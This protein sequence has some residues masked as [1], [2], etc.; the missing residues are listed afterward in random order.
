M[1]KSISLLAAAATVLSCIR[2]APTNMSYNKRSPF[3]KRGGSYQCSS[4]DNPSLMLTHFAAVFFGDFDTDGGQD[5]LGPLAVQ[6]DFKASGYYVNANGDADCSDPNDISEYALVVGT[7]VHANQVRV[8][9]A[10]DVPAETQGLQETQSSCAIKTN[11]SL[12]DFDQAQSNA[13]EASKTL[14]SMKPTLMLDSNGKLTSIGTSNNDFHIVI[15]KSCN[16]GDCNPFPGQMSDPSAML[17]GIGNWNGPQEMSWPSDGTLVFNIPIDSGSTFTL[18]GNNPTNGLDPCRTVFNFYPSDASGAYRSGDITLKRNT[19]SN[20]GGFSLAPEAHIV[21][22][23]TGAFAGTVVG[24]DYSWGGSGVEIH[25]YNAA[26]GSC[27]AFAG[28][29]PIHDDKPPSPVRPETSSAVTAT[30]TSMKSSTTESSMPTT[31][32]DSSSTEATTT[33]GFSSSEVTTTT[34]SKHHDG[35]TSSTESPNTE[36]TTTTDSSSTVA[37]T[38]TD[39]SIA[40]ATTTTS[41]KHHHDTTSSTGSSSIEATTTT[42]SSSTQA[43]TTST[44]VQTTT[45]TADHGGQ[46]CP[47]GCAAVTVTVVEYVTISI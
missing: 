2:A 16:D 3:A 19:G 5:I 30:S 34:S 39:S 14:A 9:G 18:K 44:E 1:V 32:T 13:I 20:F 8:K 33:T 24:Q 26:G 22:G 42:D 7:S 17:E 41:S 15:F 12:Y 36:A 27:S 47:P 38:T 40:E 4:D 43:T 21:D 23:S 11:V 35:T 31:T 28:C 25:N 6:G 37:T 29:F 45:T 46:T 10:A